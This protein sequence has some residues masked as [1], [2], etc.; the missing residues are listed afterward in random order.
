MT[1]VKKQL[2]RKKI[3]F[4]ANKTGIK[5]WL[6]SCLFESLHLGKVHFPIC[7]LDSSHLHATHIK[8]LKYARSKFS[9]LKKR[10]LHRWLNKKA[11]RGYPASLVFTPHGFNFSSNK[12]SSNKNKK[13]RKLRNGIS[14]RHSCRSLPGSWFPPVPTS[15]RWRRQRP[16][17]IQYRWLSCRY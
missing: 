2:S 4:K 8:L 17:P 1:I 11:P 7:D 9:T 15:A 14:S 16:C 6:P 5:T 10:T 3:L 12:A 13:E